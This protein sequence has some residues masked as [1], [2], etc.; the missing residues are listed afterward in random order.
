MSKD[1]KWRSKKN[2][3]KNRKLSY[4]RPL[5]RE[6]GWESGGGLRANFPPT[7]RKMCKVRGN[8]TFCAGKA[9]SG[10]NNKR[11]IASILLTSPKPAL[12]DVEL[13]STTMVGKTE[14]RKRGES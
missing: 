8:R 3:K 11:E 7:K 10:V 4:K 6:I 1:V 2:V 14:R 12:L 5:N 9:R 13:F